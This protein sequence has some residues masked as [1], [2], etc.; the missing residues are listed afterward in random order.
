MLTNVQQQEFRPEALQVLLDASAMLLASANRETVLAGILDLASKSLA[1]DA[2]AVWRECDGEGTWRAIAKRGLSPE[3][4]TEIK[5]AIVEPLPSIEVYENLQVEASLLQ[6]RE[7]YAAEGIRSMVVVPLNPPNT[8]PGT[9]TFYWRE[10]QTFSKLDLDHVSALANLLASA[11]YTSELHEQTRREKQRLSFLA[12]ASS[13]LASSLDYETTLNQVAQLVVPHIA[14]WCTVHIVENGVVNRLVVAHADPAMLALAKEYSQRYPEEI[15]EDRGLG[16]VLRTGQIEVYSNI[17]DEMVAQAARDPEHLALIR[18][19]KITSSILVPLESRGKVLGAIRLLAAGGER[20]YTSD[21]V[22]LATDLA[23][24]A[25]TAIDNAQLHRAVLK[26]ESELRLAHSAA[27]IGSWSMDLVAREV[28]WSDEF[29]ALHGLPLETKPTYDGGSQL[30]HPDDRERI[31]QELA[32][33]LASDADHVNTD[34]RIVTPD[35]RTLWIQS[36]GS[37]HRNQAGEPTGII[38]VSMDVTDQ[39]LAES[40]LRR[41]EKLAAAGR[42]AATVA[43]EVNNPLEALTNL[44]YLASVTE[45]LPS[46]AK[47]YLETAEGELSRMAHIVR[48]TLGFYR[49]SVNPRATDLG[50]IVDEVTHLYQSRADAR[51]V[52]LYCDCERGLLTLANA[53]EIKQV[54]ANLVSNAIDATAAGGCVHT[55]V[56]RSGPELQIIVRDTGSGISESHLTRLFEPFF[57]T[58]EDVGT[59]LG[60]WV[61]KGIVEKHRGSIRVA[62]STSE[63]SGTTFTVMLPMLERQPGLRPGLADAGRT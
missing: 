22:Q 7:V 18:R 16:A 46:Q 43:H 30:V 28:F 55:E 52:R 11:L 37:I 40:A 9:I 32:K 12:E 8:R 39:R 24:R 31:L 19:L 3:Y 48:Q 10:P 29:K 58:K 63:E 23:R 5:S 62:S 44:I 14:D 25:A 34:H 51:A 21:D 50:E 56:H 1:A 57:T 35:G 42:L 36:R 49:E 38:G 6:Y 33:V 15:R 47:S 53:G 61:S 41:T 2:Y 45:G 17:S 59:G 4:R 27:R 54:V 26:Q 13:I 20:H 60:L